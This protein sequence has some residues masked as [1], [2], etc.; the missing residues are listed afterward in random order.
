MTPSGLP[1]PWLLEEKARKRL[2]GIAAGEGDDIEAVGRY[3]AFGLRIKQLFA[4]KAAAMGKAVAANARYTAYSSDV[5]EA[6]RPVVRPWMVNASYGLAVAY[7]VGDIGYTVYKESKKPGADL[8]RATAHAVCF[9]G[10]ASLALPAVII[11]QTVHAAQGVAKRAGRFTK[12]GPTL[13]GLALIPMLPTLL[14]EPVEHGLEWAFAS[15]WPTPGAQQQRHG[16]GGGGTGDEHTRGAGG[17][18]RPPTFA[19]RA[20][21]AGAIE[22]AHGHAHGK[23]D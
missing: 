5:G 21:Q 22:R 6:F 1:D 17:V 19:E 15:Y 10:I 8:T 20:L 23:T 12:W 14:D 16:G 7:I 11:H 9:Q 4:I 18:W 2:N 13:A 3:A